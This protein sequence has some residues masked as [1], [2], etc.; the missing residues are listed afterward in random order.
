VIAYAAA[1]LGLPSPPEEPFATAALSGLARSFYEENR[2]VRNG[3]LSALGWTPR[4]PSYREGLD[5]VLAEE[6]D[7]FARPSAG[8]EP[9]VDRQ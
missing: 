2:R 6:R 7:G 8:G 9:A 4:Y 1:L 3:R 5:A